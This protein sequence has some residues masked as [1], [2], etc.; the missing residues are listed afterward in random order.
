MS[1]GHVV[2]LNGAPSV[3]KSSTA[4]ALQAMLTDPHYYLGLDEYRRGYLDRVWLADDGALFRRM[5]GPFIRNLATLA[6]AGHDVIA[7]SMLTSETATLYLDVFRDVQVIFVGLECRLDVAKV[8]EADRAD[9]RKGPMNLDHPLLRTLHDHGC[10]D[11][12]LDTSETTAREIASR[13]VPV[14]RDPPL[15]SAFD[16][17]RST[18]NGLVTDADE[19]WADHRDC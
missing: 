10:Y 12:R 13:I 5:I 6:R 9:R 19:R 8:R 2:F 18:S 17:L 15:P 3:G 1:A 14:L 4:H 16:R 7:E 11:L